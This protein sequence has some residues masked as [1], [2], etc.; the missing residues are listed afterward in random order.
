M[1]KNKMTPL[2]PWAG[3]KRR[4]I[5]HYLPLLPNPSDYNTYVEPFFGAGAMFCHLKNQKPN[6]KCHIND[7]NTGIVNIYLAIQN[8]VE[9]FIEV[10]DRLDKAYI[11]LDDKDRK[12]FYSDVRHEHAWHYEKWTK[13]EE[14]A[15]LF[16]LIRTSFC[17]MQLKSKK[18]NDRFST[19][20]GSTKQ[21]TKSIYEP[22]NIRAWHQAFKTTTITNLDWKEVVKDIPKQNTFF[23]FDPPYRESVISYPA[24][25]DPFTDDDQD[26]L[27]QFCV[28]I[29]DNKGKVFFCNRELNDNFWEGKT[30]S[31]KTTKIGGGSYTGGRWKMKEK[32]LRTEAPDVLFYSDPENVNTLPV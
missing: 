19:A 5:K 31:L 12:T 14:A 13:T 24:F 1:V 15:N 6:L 22:E 11:P 32:N 16:F 3:G 28:D 10:V 20:I 25:G 9:N 4:M 8:D 7:I 27:L 18:F 21:L 29:N 30:G 17:G 26:E 23:F 2:F